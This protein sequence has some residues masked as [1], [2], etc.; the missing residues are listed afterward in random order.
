MDLR[1]TPLAGEFV[2]LEPLEEGHADALW[3]ATLDTDVWRWM[4]YHLHSADEMSGFISAARK[5]NEAGVALGFAIALQG[6]GEPVGLTGY[7]NADHGHRRVEIGSTWVTRAHQR[8]RVNT[9][10]KFLLLRHAFETQDCVRVEFKTDARNKRSR[11]ALARIG[12][13]EEGVLRHHMV[14]PDGTLRDS[15][16]FS[17]LATEWPAV[18]ERLRGFLARGRTG[19]KS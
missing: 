14:L 8:T 7:W 19:G 17:I 9:E 5:L 6:S 11:S 13:I 15:V 10:A 4:P 1:P 18:R 16:Y 3:K 12:A 2:R